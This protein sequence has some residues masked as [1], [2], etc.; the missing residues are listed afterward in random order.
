V[1]G[2][3]PRHRGGGKGGDRTGQH[4]SAVTRDAGDAAGRRLGDGGQQGRTNRGADLTAGVSATTKQ[5][6][7]TTA[8]TAAPS[9]SGDVQPRTSP[10]DML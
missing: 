1:T 7:A 6:P 8:T 10:W 3:L 9:T 2:R 4:R 5:A